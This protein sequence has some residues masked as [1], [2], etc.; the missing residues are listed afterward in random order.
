MKNYLIGSELVV[1]D[2]I[3]ISF[4]VV[5]TLE[6]STLLLKNTTKY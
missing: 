1:V 6:A 2:H 5:T 4:F 3:I